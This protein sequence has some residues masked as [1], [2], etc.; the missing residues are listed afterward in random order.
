VRPDAEEG[1]EGTGGGDCE[2]SVEVTRGRPMA[3]ASSRSGLVEKEG[4]VQVS[5]KRER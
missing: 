1:T 3:Y 2:G 5:V 4:I